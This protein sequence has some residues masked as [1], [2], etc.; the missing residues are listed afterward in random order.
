[1]LC[2]AN[3]FVKL[4]FSLHFNFTH[5]VSVISVPTALVYKFSLLLSPLVYMVSGTD[6]Q[7]IHVC[8]VVYTVRESRRLEL[9]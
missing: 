6:A 4:I 2:N 5:T 8:I 7:Y 3:F 1:M 9:E